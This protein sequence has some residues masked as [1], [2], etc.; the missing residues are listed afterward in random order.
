MGV[1]P[2]TSNDLLGTNRCCVMAEVALAHDG[3]LGFA[4]A[5]IDVAAAAGA[6]AVK[7]QTHLADAEST[8]RERWRVPFSRQ[9]ASRYDYWRRTAFTEPEWRGLAEHAR[10]RHLHFLSSPFSVE[11]FELLDRVGVAAWKLASGEVTNVPLIERMARN[12]RLVILSSGMST[13]RELDR[14][15]AI[16]RDAGAAVAVLQ[17]TTA[18]PCAP[19]D[20]GLNMI[21]TLRRRYDCPVGLSDHSGTIYAGLAAA[22]LGAAIVEVHVTFSRSMFGPDVPASLTP[23]ELG[24]L[25]EGVRFVERAMANPVDKDGMAARF[26]DLRDLFGKS[27]VA[28]RDLPAGTVLS[29]ADLAIKKPGGDLPPDRLDSVIGRTLSRALTRDEPVRESDLTP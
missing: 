27:V 1:E 19:E 13:L 26:S 10:E 4:H 11:A 9:D 3:S 22:V 12:G 18:Y 7:F 23:E 16:C 25:V 17:A 8:A 14:A 20:T 28:R 15:V 21:D 24:R 5:F 29:A 2:Q 6:D